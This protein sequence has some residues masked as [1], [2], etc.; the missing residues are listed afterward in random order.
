MGKED[1]QWHQVKKPDGTL[2][3]WELSFPLGEQRVF[4]IAHERSWRAEA[5]GHV[6]LSGTAEDFDDSRCLAASNTLQALSSV[7]RSLRSATRGVIH[8]DLVMKGKDDE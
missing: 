7:H 2:D 8:G 6:I 3:R 4:L 5:N 1:F